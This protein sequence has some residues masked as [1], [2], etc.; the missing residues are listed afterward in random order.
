MSKKQGKRRA[1]ISSLMSLVLCLS[2][3]IGTTMAW[4]TD[5]VTNNGNRIE[6]GGI[7]VQLLKYN[8]TEYVDISEDDGKGDIFTYEYFI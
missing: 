3:L 6:T 2:M 1:V 4:F 8:G 5:T 7:G